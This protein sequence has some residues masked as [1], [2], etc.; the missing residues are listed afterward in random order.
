MAAFDLPLTQLEQYTPD[1]PEPDDFDDFWRSSLATAAG[2]PLIMSRE[3]VEAA[4]TGIE[5]F[6]TWDVAFSGFGGY[7]CGRGTPCPPVP[8][9]VPGPVPVPVPG[10][11]AMPGPAA[12]PIRLRV[13]QSWNSSATAAG[14][15]CRM[16]G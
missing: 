5:A 11:I 14:A 1:V 6:D 15:A 2:S 12:A 3:R 9:P 8:V 10:P 16:S 13:P 7:R 4:Q